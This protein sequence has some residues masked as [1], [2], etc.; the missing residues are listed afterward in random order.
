[1][2]VSEHMCELL[3]ERMIKLM[4]VVWTLRVKCDELPDRI[5]VVA[6]GS[7]GVFEKRLECLNEYYEYPG[8]FKCSAC[9]YSNADTCTGTVSSFN[10]CPECGRK[11][12]G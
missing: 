5:E 12:S 3:S 11:V 7:V 10:Y 1:M 6:D 8:L 9:G 4:P 2:G